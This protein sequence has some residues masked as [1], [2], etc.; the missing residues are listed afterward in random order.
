MNKNTNKSLIRLVAG[1]LFVGLTLWW[2]ILSIINPSSDY[3]RL[4]FAASYGSMALLGGIYGLISA[5]KWGSFKSAIGRAIVF[6]ACALL[7][8]ELGQLVFSYY[9]IVKKVDIP[10]PGIADIGFFGN[11]L[12]YIIGGFFLT[13]VLSVKSYVKKAPIKLFISIL[14]P[15]IL[16]ST[17][18]YFF[19]RGYSVAG[20]SKLQV[21]LDFSY[22]LG[23][24]IYVS[25]ALVTLLS[26]GKFVGGIMRGPLL[27][28]LFALIVQYSAD[29]NFLYQNAHETWTNGGYGDY[30]YLL[31]YS[32]MTFSLIYLSAAF[33]KIS[34][35]H[36]NEKISTS[37]GAQ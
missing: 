6:L 14:L 26:V 28:I 31:A 1:F 9:N 15:L 20:T 5:E 37:E 18:Y 8:A 11:M 35:P 25:I 24:A 22:P 33:Q 12:F 17:S 36:S 21:F 16:L 3:P 30:L 27:L 29:F 4:V 13:K 2:I 34:L 10:Y 32:V 19:L 23:D 7:F